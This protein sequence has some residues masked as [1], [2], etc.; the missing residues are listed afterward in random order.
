MA[1]RAVT[2]AKALLDE[3][4]GWWAW[5]WASESNKTRVRSSIE[6]ATH[7]LDREI[8]RAKNSWEHPPASSDAKKLKAAEAD[9]QAA[10]ALAKKIFDE[11]EQEFNASKAC[12]GA[13]EAKRA[14]EK[15]EVVLK[16]ARAGK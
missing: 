5:T 7:V 8:A 9:F 2:E 6:N 3:A 10:T 16:L 1:L 15:H 14:I 11:A 4:Q 13:L 12:Q